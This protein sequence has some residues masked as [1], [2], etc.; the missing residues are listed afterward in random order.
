VEMGSLIVV[1]GM[2]RSVVSGCDLGVQ[3]SVR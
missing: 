1:W 3:H 2:I